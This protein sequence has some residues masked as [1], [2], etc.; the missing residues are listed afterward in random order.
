MIALSLRAAGTA[1]AI[2]L[3]VVVM[4]W[5]TWGTQHN[6]SRGNRLLRWLQ[7]GLPTVGKR[8][9]VRWLGS[10]AVE[11]GIVEPSPPFA[12]MTVLVV[13]EPRDVPWFWALARSRGRRDFLIFRARL[14]GSPGFELEILDPSGWTGSERLAALDTDAWVAADWGAPELRVF[15]APGPGPDAVRPILD[16][17]VGATDGV[18]RLSVRREPPHVEVHV[19]PPDPEVGDAAE[20][21]RA[22]VD[23]ARTVAR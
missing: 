17:L 16:R 23:V 6:I 4:L 2:V 15:H 3:L 10:S 9:T 11:L 7:A 13:L 12:E 20:L 8:S 22:V 1:G 21:V 18:W 14:R 5:F 19:R